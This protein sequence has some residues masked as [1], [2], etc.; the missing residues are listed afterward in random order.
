MKFYMKTHQYYCGIDLHA[1]KLYVCILD[2]EG[3]ICVHKNIQAGP[4][5]LLNLIQP[6][7][8]D[9]VLVAEKSENA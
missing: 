1:R 6:F 8:H 9:M 3:R 4:E 2:S 7:Q 5:P